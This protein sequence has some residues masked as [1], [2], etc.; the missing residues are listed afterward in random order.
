MLHNSLW[1]NFE[2]RGCIQ[3]YSTMAPSSPSRG[4]KRKRGRR[5]RGEPSTGAPGVCEPKLPRENCQ[6]GMAQEPGSFFPFPFWFKFCLL[7]AWDWSMIV[8]MRL[9]LIILQVGPTSQHFVNN[10]ADMACCD[11]IRCMIK[12]WLVI[13]CCWL[14]LDL[15][16]PHG[17][18]WG[19]LCWLHP[20]D[21]CQ[22]LNECS[23]IGLCLLRCMAWCIAMCHVGVE[24]AL[25][26]LATW[27]VGGAHMSG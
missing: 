10:Q 26:Q 2:E 22:V 1:R 25:P 8:D 21:S 3:L 17:T 16:M 11:R 20:M 27:H 14:C 6:R 24:V 4:R 19:P 7:F 12:P 5:E 13:N 23:W 18:K 9:C 15:H